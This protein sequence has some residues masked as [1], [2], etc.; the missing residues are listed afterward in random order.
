MKPTLYGHPF[1]LYTRKAHLALLHK[2]IDFDFKTTMPRSQDEPFKSISP[3]G[4]I[5]AYQDHI[6]GFSDSSVIAHHV[7]LEYPGPALTPSD[8]KARNQCLW[9]DKYADGKMTPIIAG[10]L[11]AEVVMAQYV[12]KRPV[13]QADI[14]KA[15]NEELPAL[16]PFLNQQLSGSQWLTGEALCLADISVGGLLVTLLHTGQTIPDS[17]PNV[18]AYAERF[19]ALP[20][21]QTVLAGELKVMQAVGYPSPLAA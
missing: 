19:L 9:W 6:D 8:S 14:D 16:Y 10:H 2:G 1:S 5:P 11:F 21:V 20:M 18:Q 7:D 3:L 4:K 12:F 15:I 13:I 17:A